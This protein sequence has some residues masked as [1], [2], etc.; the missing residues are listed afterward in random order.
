MRQPQSS[1]SGRTP[2][3]AVRMLPWVESG[4]HFC[5]L[6]LRKFINGGAHIVSGL[7][8]AASAACEEK[9]HTTSPN[10]VALLFR[11][12]KIEGLTVASF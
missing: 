7:L 10:S 8:I 12:R 5:P 4:I 2:V 9:R 11:I 3:K 1:L 6:R